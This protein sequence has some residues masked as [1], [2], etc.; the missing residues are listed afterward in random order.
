MRELENQT[1]IVT[2]ASSGIG[3]GVAKALAKEG[4]AAIVNYSSSAEK[5]K[6]VVT[7]INET[8][9]HATLIQA[10]VGNESDVIEMFRQAIKEFG[11]V[12]ILVNNAGLQ[13]DA[14]FHDLTLDDWNRVLGVN[15]TGQF[16]CAREAVKEFLRRGVV[17]ERS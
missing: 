3:A 5:A 1:A 9:G 17:L 15:L 16:L 6:K 12:D 7:E 14:A 13:M 4:A 8:G 2:G 11:T 10:D